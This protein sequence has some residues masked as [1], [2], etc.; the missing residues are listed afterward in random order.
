MILL[1]TLN[2]IEKLKAFLKSV[3]DTKTTAPGLILVDADDYGK[4]CIGYDDIARNNMPDNWEFKITQAVTMG[5]KCR[6]VIPELNVNWVGLVND[7]HECVTE[8]WDQKLI[9]KL[10]GKNFV[11]ANDRTLNAYRLPVTATAW[12]M[13]LLKAVGW[14]IYPP[15]LEH[16][17]IDNLWLNLGKATGSWRMVAGCIVTHNHVLFGKAESDDTHTKVYGENFHKG[18]NGGLWLNDE[19]NFNKFMQ[20]EFQATVQKIK[21]FQDYLPGQAWNPEF[22]KPKIS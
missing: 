18:E 20:T 13:D 3:K 6:E 17:F 11:S 5:G 9:A 4:N 14:P 22:N 21:A 8:G 15:W 2:R 12:S 10:D 19:A 7:D 1:P 16:L